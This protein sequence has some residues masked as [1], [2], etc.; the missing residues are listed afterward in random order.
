MAPERWEDEVT[1]RR[2]RFGRNWG[3]FLR[4]LDEDRIAA[5]E[6]SIRRL[7]G[8]S[9][10]RGKTFLDIG[11][12]SGLFSLAARRLGGRVHSIDFDPECVACTAS[13]KARFFPG[14][15]DWT[16]ERASV[17]DRGYL[18]S[19][20]R[21]DVVYSWGVLHHTGRM[22]EALENVAGLVGKNGLIAVALYN[23]VGGSSRRWA[24]VK[25]FYNRMPA[26][27]QL[28]M[29][30]GYAAACE[31]R[32]ALTRLLRRQNPLPFPDWRAR[33]KE[34]G[35]SPWYD[36]VDWVGG[37]PFEVASPDEVFRFYRSRNFSLRE[38]RTRRGHSCNE[39]V[40]EKL[41]DAR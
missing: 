7:L 36:Y 1:G 21:F 10:L 15:D 12:G 2:F 20:G 30:G 9:D 27:A 32:L 18:R 11:S 33:K 23:D 19:L 14:D 4:L 8:V 37:Y 40:F 25:A 5:A 39:Y 31:S 22:W 3:R 41:N 28:L 34:R 26:A 16:V 13:L 38:L 17:L 6:D 35:M 29:V 24:R